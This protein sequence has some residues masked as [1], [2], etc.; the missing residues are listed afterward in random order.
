MLSKSLFQFSVDGWGCVPSLLFDL[1]SNY[2]RSSED[3]G[4]L[5]QKAPC[6][7]CCNSVSPSLQQA[8][9]NAH[10]CQRLLDI[11]GQV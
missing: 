2:G 8:I 1:R 6:M 4:D 5:L 7:H 9:T 3:N 10:F 11:H